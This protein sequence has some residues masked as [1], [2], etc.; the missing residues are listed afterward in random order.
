MI[1][2]ILLTKIEQDERFRVVKCPRENVTDETIIYRSMFLRPSESHEY[3]GKKGHPSEAI[4]LGI[5]E[6]KEDE[7][8]ESET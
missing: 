3:R 1:G 6:K 7:Y 2:H 4:V 5:C 8:D